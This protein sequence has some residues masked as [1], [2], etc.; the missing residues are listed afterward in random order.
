MVGSLGTLVAAAVLASSLASSA[1][2][3]SA[4]SDTRTAIVV[5]AIVFVRMM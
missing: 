5:P 1:A 2:S 3:A 4:T